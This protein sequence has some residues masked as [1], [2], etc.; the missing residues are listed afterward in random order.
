MVVCKWPGL[1][2]FYVWVLDNYFWNVYDTGRKEAFG[3]VV[4]NGYQPITNF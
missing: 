3:S 2:H 4:S 1:S